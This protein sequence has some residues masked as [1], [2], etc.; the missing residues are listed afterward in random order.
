MLILLLYTG[1]AGLQPTQPAWDSVP[2]SHRIL[3]AEKGRP[4]D[5]RVSPVVL[6]IYCVAGV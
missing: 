3:R 2:F 5:K 4:A 6:V 1:T